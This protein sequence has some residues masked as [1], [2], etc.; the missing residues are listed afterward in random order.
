MLRT[1]SCAP[2]TVFQMCLFPFLHLIYDSI[3]ASVKSHTIKKLAYFN[4]L[5]WMLDLKLLR[6]LIP[7]M[8][9]NKILYNLM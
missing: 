1:G 7:T 5:I 6:V 9:V 8:Q 4:R 2:I 3:G